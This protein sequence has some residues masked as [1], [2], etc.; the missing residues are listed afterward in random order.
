M[1]T[2]ILLAALALT[3]CGGTGGDDATAPAA[4]REQHYG[5]QCRPTYCYN[6]D[7]SIVFYCAQSP[8]PCDAPPTE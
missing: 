2:A 8:V 7:G 1:K 5:P 6:T 4:A 3:A